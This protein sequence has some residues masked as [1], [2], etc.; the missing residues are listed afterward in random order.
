MICSNCGKKNEQGSKFCFVCGTKLEVIAKS[1]VKSVPE[2]KEREKAAGTALIPLDDI[3]VSDL[4]TR[5]L[6]LAALIYKEDGTELEL[7]FKPQILIGRTD[8]ISQNFPDIDL[9][10]LDKNRV[11]SR[12]HALISYSEGKYRIKDLGS[13]NGI[14]VNGSRLNTENEYALKDGY[15]ITFGKLEFTFKYSS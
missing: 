4:S 2:V 1:E 8:N 15:E 3:P 6:I 9:T 7:P 14:C 12:K 13:M 10:E 5:P 11:T